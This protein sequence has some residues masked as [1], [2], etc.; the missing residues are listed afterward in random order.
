MARRFFLSRV[1]KLRGLGRIR[2]LPLQVT[3]TVRAAVGEKVMV[4]AV[5]RREMR[6]MDLMVEGSRWP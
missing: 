3:G 1:R 5:K 6:R 2:G 4:L